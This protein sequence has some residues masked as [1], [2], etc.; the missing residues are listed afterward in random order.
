MVKNPPVMRE[1]WV[2][3]LG[4]EDPLKKDMATHSIIFSWRIPMD[5]G[6]W[7]AIVHEVAELD[8]TEQLSTCIFKRL[9]KNK[10][11]EKSAYFYKVERRLL[12]YFKKCFAIFSASH[13][14]KLGIIF[15]FFQFPCTVRHLVSLFKNDQNDIYLQY[16][17]YDFIYIKQ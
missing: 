15:F 17:H 10:W 16:H 12:C 11:R 6:A 1:K 5:R 9:E 2:W 3:S 13:L 4:W 7:W 14:V 8:M